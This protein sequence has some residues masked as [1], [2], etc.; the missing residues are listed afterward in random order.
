MR[1]LVWVLPYAWLVKM[2]KALG[3]FIMRRAKKVRKITETNLRLCFPSLSDKEHSAFLLETFESIGLCIIETALAWWAPVKKIE[4]LIEYRGIEHLHNA[5]AK[6]NGLLVIGPHIACL[7]IV[8]RLCTLQLPF[9]VVYR[10]QRNAFLESITKRSLEKH[11]THAIRRE[12]LRLILR[13]LKNNEI[14][15]YTPDV[16]PGKSNSVFAPFFGIPAA[17][18]TATSRFAKLTNA[19]VIPVHFARNADASGY[20]VTFNPPLENF[21]GENVE[22]DTH[23]INQIMETIIRKN[24]EQYIWQYKRF[25]TRPE[26]E[27]DF[28]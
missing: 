20:T 23:R 7:E 5:L 17:S 9:S 13:C 15:W 8:G 1:L 6:E 12:N 18:L 16:D 10:K 14:V 21:P 2:G 11:Y 26:G 4:P 3:R 25:K 27:P 22:K 28:Y 19:A 24:P